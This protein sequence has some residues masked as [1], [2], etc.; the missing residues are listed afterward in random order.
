[1][2]L[3]VNDNML[4]IEPEMPFG[5]CGDM[6]WDLDDI[7]FLLEMQGAEYIEGGYNYLCFAFDGGKYEIN[8]YDASILSVG[9][10]VEV[11]I[12]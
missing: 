6:E 8:N 1:M 3:N 4:I 10:S 12:W 2:L 11:Y 9:R 7:M 5:W